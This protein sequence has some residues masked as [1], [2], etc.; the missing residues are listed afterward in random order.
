MKPHGRATQITLHQQKEIRPEIIRRAG[1]PVGKIRGFSAVFIQRMGII[2]Q[3][4]RRGI[5]LHRHKLQKF[6]H[7]RVRWQGNFF[8][9]GFPIRFGR[10]GITV[11]NTVPPPTTRSF[12]DRNYFGAGTGAAGAAG[13]GSAGGAAGV[14]AVGAGSTGVAGVG[15]PGVAGGTG[16]SSLGASNG[17]FSPPGAGAVAFGSKVREGELSSVLGVVG[18]TC[19]PPGGVEGVGAGVGSATKGTKVGSFMARASRCSIAVAR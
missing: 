16:F 10:H 3:C 15:V 11:L 14:G 2:C 6:L 4:Q 12:S 7:L 19:K 13:A 9:D 8:R 18:L 5:A 1:L 17:D